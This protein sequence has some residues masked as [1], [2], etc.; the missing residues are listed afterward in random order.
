M[1]TLE[2]KISGLADDGRTPGALLDLK[3]V[4]HTC[5]TLRGAPESCEEVVRSTSK[6]C[7]ECRNQFFA[8]HGRNP[9]AVQLSGEMERRLQSEMDTKYT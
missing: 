3:R 9:H 7:D 1:R 8:A 4:Q 6:V 5:R 2:K